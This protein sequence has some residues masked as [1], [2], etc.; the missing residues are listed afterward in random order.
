M[1]DDF[2]LLSSKEVASLIGRHVSTVN[3]W[4]LS[5]VLPEPI[6]DTSKPAWSRYQIRIWIEAKQIKANESTRQDSN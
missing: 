2:K 4:R 3:R 5:G 1:D 6:I